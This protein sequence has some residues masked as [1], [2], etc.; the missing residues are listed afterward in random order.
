MKTLEQLI[1][2]GYAESKEVKMYAVTQW[3]EIHG[4]ERYAKLQTEDGS[5]WGYGDEDQVWT[6]DSN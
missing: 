3:N 1:E 2:Q 5:V 4:G 6:P